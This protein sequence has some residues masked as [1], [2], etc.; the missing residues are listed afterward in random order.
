M[1]MPIFVSVW[2][3]FGVL[4]HV[5]VFFDQKN[6]FNKSKYI[7]HLHW[8]DVYLLHWKNL[9][10]QKP[11]QKCHPFHHENLP[12]PKGRQFPLPT[13][14]TSGRQ[15]L[16]TQTCQWDFDGTEG[17][18]EGRDRKTLSGV[19]RKVRK[20][21]GGRIQKKTEKPPLPGPRP[22]LDLKWWIV[23]LI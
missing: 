18:C 15:S 1:I 11:S 21:W 12:D 16:G 4:F 7:Y 17:S 22:G 8:I 9:R 13:H 19:Q 5:N 14:P 2:Y 6:I 3:V 23:I 10:E 20:F